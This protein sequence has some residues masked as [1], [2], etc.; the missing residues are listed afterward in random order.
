[1]KS[2]LVYKFTC[3]SCYSS[4]IDETYHHFKTSIEERIKKDNK[5]IFLNIYTQLQHALTHVILFLFKIT[6]KANSKFG[7]KIKEPS[8]INWRKPN[9]NVQ[10]KHLSLTL[11]M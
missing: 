8:Y 7:V 11:L 9:L 3:A 10:Q 1:M 4:Y 2:F 5:L 6:D